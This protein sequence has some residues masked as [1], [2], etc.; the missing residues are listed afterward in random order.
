MR[1]NRLANR[2]KEFFKGINRTL[3]LLLGAFPFG[4]IYGALAVSSGFSLPAVMAMSVFVFAGSSQFIAV[5]LYAAQAPVLII[6]LVTFVVNLRHLLYSL[7]LLPYLKH[8]P[9]RWRIPLSFWLTDETFAVSIFRYQESENIDHNEYFQLGSSLS[10]YL[11]WQFWSFVGMILGERI[12]NA[13]NWGLDVHADNIHRN[14]YPICKNLGD[15]DLCSCFWSFSYFNLQPA[16]QTWNH[17]IYV[18]WNI[19]WVNLESDE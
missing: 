11:N 17:F 5:G 8:L 13:Q 19:S 1:H 10:M 6:I 2:R 4:L 15:A 16:I 3:P 12:P 9:H 14:D 18:D 7:S